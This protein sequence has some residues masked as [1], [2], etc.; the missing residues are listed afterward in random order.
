MALLLDVERSDGLLLNYHRISKMSQ[1]EIPINPDEAIEKN[2]FAHGLVHVEKYISKETR[3]AGKRPVETTTKPVNL[4][5]SEVAL[6]A[7]IS[8]LALK[9]TDE[10]Y[11][12]AEDHIE[13]ADLNLLPLLLGLNNRELGIAY[14]GVKAILESRSDHPDNYFNDFI[15]LINR[16]PL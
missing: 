3:D 14:F 16:E 4:L 2:E 10:N 15:E 6:M 7:R 1:I 11:S 12:L 13:Q 9:R 8:Y 5:P